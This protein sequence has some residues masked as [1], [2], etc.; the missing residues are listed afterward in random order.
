MKGLHYT[1]HRYP[2]PGQYSDPDQYS[3]AR[4]AVLKAV[5][6]TWGACLEEAVAPQQLD[7][8]RKAAVPLL[9]LPP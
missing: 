6:G 3:N 4:V 5:P 2:D 7:V 9:F 1:H 8:W